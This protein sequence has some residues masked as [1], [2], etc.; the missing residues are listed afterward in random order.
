MG[1]KPEPPI[2]EQLKGRKCT[3]PKDK[4]IVETNRKGK[5]FKEC[6]RCNKFMGWV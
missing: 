6:T 2:K 1:V 3:H 4:I 5:K